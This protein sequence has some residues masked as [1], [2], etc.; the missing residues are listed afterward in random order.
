MK[1]ILLTDLHR[2][3]DSIKTEINKAIESVLKEKSFIRGSFVEQF[4][5]NFSKATGVPYCVG[6]G[7]G[8]EALYIALKTLNVG[9]GDEVI[10]AANSFIATS[11]AITM[12]GAKV[13]FADCDNF[14]GIDPAQIKRKITP[15]TKAVIPVHLY[16]QMADMKAI[17]EIAR[18]YNLF[19][20][21]DAAQAV[22][23]G[24]NGN[25][26]GSYGHFAAFSFYPGKNLGAYGDAGALTTKDH[27]L[28]IKAKMFAN[29]GRTNKYDHEFEGM[30]SRMDGIQGAILDVKLKYLP[31]W[32]RKRAEIAEKYAT[33]LKKIEMVQVPSIRPGAKHVFHLYPIRVNASVRDAL[34]IHLRNSGIMAGVHYPIALP[35][36]QAYKHLGH[37]P[38][39]F[40]NATAFSKQLIS[41][42]I[43][44]ELQDDEINYVLEKVEERMS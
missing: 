20:I 34:L 44:P 11:E 28:F 41:L 25:P 5:K 40:P 31:E 2:Q 21:E 30:N 16:G 24:F 19:V 12:T 36:S 29:H 15:S 14:Y 33:R 22:L 17:M 3:Y 27:D 8:T 38:E 35:N 39:D 26:P 18:K 37:H 32:T 7:N 9:P 23:A 43:F 6:V 4:E 42:P 1:K 10:T 13:V